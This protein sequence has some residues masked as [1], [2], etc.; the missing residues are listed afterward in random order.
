MHERVSAPSSKSARRSSYI[1]ESAKAQ[2]RRRR[3]TAFSAVQPGA[4]KSDK[5]GS[6]PLGARGQS[7]KAAHR[8]SALYPS[9]PTIAPKLPRAPRI[10]YN[11]D[12]RFGGP[13]SR[14]LLEEL[15]ACFDSL[16][17]VGEPVR[18]RQL[19]QNAYVSVPV[20]FHT[21]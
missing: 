7:T 6:I 16:E 10:W 4:V 1:A 12:K 19:L 14:I 5:V 3:S 2:C 11:D 20:M 18:D 21:R 15:I 17:L 8:A 13:V 9:L